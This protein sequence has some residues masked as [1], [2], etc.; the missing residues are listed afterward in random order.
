MV[1]LSLTSHRQIWPHPDIT[2]MLDV[3]SDVVLWQIPVA[4]LYSVLEFSLYCLKLISV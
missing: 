1:S 4:V 2:E 3:I